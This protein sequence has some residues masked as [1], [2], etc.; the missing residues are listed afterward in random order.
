[1]SKIESW[2]PSPIY[3]IENIISEKE[4]DKLVEYIKWKT[5]EIESG[6]EEWFTDVY[7]THHTFCLHKDNVFHNLCNIVKNKTDEFA[8]KLG[9]DANYDMDES[10]FNIYN[11]GDYQEYH[12]HSCCY[13]SAVYWFTNP[14]GSGNLIFRNPL[15]PIMM[16]LKNLTP[17]KYTYFNCFYNPPPCSI[18]IFPSSLLHMVQRCKNKTPRI[19]GAF[20]LV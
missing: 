5:K 13:F 4:N 16:P 9:S 14:E 12:H 10:W 1:M 11:D 8:K 15:E 3:Y 20:N 7:N 17:N 6:G 2:F 19:T 18:V